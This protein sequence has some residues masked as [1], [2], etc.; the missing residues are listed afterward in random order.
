M[1]FDKS[2]SSKSKS[3]VEPQSFVRSFSSSS[4]G[5]VNDVYFSFAP[6]KVLAEWPSLGAGIGREWE[7]DVTGVGGFE[8]E[9]EELLS[10]DGFCNERLEDAEV[11]DESV[12]DRS[13][14][15]AGGDDGW[16]AGD[17]E[18]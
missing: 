7:G 3:K 8:E 12:G 2:E 6:P 9:E 15:D 11:R 10:G 16:Y 13:A 5:A 1:S 17:G 14:G 18:L 4:F